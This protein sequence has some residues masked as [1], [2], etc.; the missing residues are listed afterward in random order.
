MKTGSRRGKHHY[1]CMIRELLTW[2]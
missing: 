2:T 1:A